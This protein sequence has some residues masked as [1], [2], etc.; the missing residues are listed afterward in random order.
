MKQCLDSDCE[1]ILAGIIK[2]VKLDLLCN[3]KFVKTHI[4]VEKRKNG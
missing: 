1:D 3:F 2:P 4:F